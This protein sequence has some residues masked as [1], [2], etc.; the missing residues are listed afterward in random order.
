MLGYLATHLGKCSLVEVVL[1]AFAGVTPASRCL[2][3]IINSLKVAVY[4]FNGAAAIT[5]LST[6]E[7]SY[8][9]TLCSLARARATGG[10]RCMSVALSSAAFLQNGPSSNAGKP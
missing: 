3:L 9:C 6:E 8:D 10:T 4:T 2:V 1:L 5:T 7:R